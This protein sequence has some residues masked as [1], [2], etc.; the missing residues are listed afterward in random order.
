MDHGRA[1]LAILPFLGLDRAGIG[2]FGVQL[3]VELLAGQF[4]RDHAV[5]GVGQLVVGEMP[6]SFGHRRGEVRLEVGDA[7]AGGRGDHEHRLGLE[8][9]GEPRGEHQQIVLLGDVD[10]VEH[11]NL[12]LAARLRRL[13]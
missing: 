6:R 10:L 3:E 7:V 1:V 11:E 12:G 5:G 13:R 2:Q 4:G 9:F 8:P